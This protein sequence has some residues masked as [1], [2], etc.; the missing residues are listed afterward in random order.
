MKRKVKEM[1][2]TNEKAVKTRRKHKEDQEA[3]Y[4]EK[5]RIRE[6][7]KES[8]LR[9]LDDPS[10]SSADQMKAVEIL[11]ELMKGR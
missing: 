5:I 7:M 11:H 3:R 6:K 2:N 8:C 4:R 1:T 9:I 10:T